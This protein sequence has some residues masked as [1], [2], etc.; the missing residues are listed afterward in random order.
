LASSA[1]R[2]AEQGGA[3]A[4][5]DEPVA[6]PD[7]GGRRAG[8]R[9]VSLR[10][11]ACVAEATSTRALPAPWRAALESLLQD[12]VGDRGAVGVLVV[13]EPG[14]SGAHGDHADG[15]VGRVVEVT[16]SDE[17]PPIWHGMHSRCST[18]TG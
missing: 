10:S 13:P 7:R 18:P 4:Q 14:R 15:V 5:A 9:L 17:T 2:A 8:M 1:S 6:P 16:V 3:L 11:T 12:P